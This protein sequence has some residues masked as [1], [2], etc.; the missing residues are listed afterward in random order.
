MLGP[1]LAEKYRVGD[2]PAIYLEPSNVSPATSHLLF[3]YFLIRDDR[4]GD[5]E[6]VCST[7]YN[8]CLVRKRT[9]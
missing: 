1:K 4:E 6:S 7:A 8:L 3:R 9:R 5:Q 2:T